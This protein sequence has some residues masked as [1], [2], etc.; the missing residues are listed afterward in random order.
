[1]KKMWSLAMTLIMLGS[2]VLAQQSL[3][4]YYNEL[5]KDSE[6]V[7]Y[8]LDYQTRTSTDINVIKSKIE[9]LNYK[10]DKITN[11]KT[12]QESTKKD[13]LKKLNDEVSFYEYRLDQLQK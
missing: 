10:I 11:D 4:E 7:A 8:E 12:I 1:M 9:K 5:Y 3:Q 2:L 13:A 6:Q